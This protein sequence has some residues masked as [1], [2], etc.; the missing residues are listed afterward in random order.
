[1]VEQLRTALHDD[2]LDEAAAKQ[3][4]RC[5]ERLGKPLRVTVFGSSASYASDLAN[6]LIGKRVLGTESES[7]LV[8]LLHNQ[9]ERAR[10]IH[11][12]NSQ[13][14]LRGP[15]VSNAFANSPRMVEL[16]MDLPSLSKMTVVRAA[17]DTI[18]GL[19]GAIKWAVPK[20]DV[21]IWCTMSFTAYD[22][23]L[24]LDLPEHIRDRGY[25]VVRPGYTVGHRCRELFRSVLQVDARAASAARS[26]AG[27]VNKAAFRGAGGTDLI[28]TMRREIELAERAASDA[29][30][31]L[32]KRH[33]EPALK[34]RPKSICD[35]QAIEKNAKMSGLV[36]GQGDKTPDG[37]HRD[38]VTPLERPLVRADASTVKGPQPERPVRSRPI[39]HSVEEELTASII[40][41]M[42]SKNTDE[43]A[44]NS[45]SD[46]LNPR[47]V[48]PISRTR[49]R[50][51]L[52][53]NEA[54]T[55]PQLVEAPAHTRHPADKASQTGTRG[56]ERK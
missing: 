56:S 17:S 39:A 28:K 53:Q 3:A 20:T 14:S 21:A 41:Q 24:W 40:S 32:M 42:F 27:D 11:N 30:Y 29:A 1:M 12:D 23:A 35:I 4:R 34:N 18:N 15:D 25:L 5:L 6:I 22:L 43:K 52:R 54:E 45:S 33:I 44:E 55:K 26:D 50:P 48:R 16:G 9:S 7:S 8:R 51:V 13:S 37:H 2:L 49:S 31:V 46:Q 36:G 19:N 38:N 47:R 10:I